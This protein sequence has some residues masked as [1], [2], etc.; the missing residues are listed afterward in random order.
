MARCRMLRGGTTYG[1][2]AE[3]GEMSVH[4]TRRMSK[5]G[6][7]Q[8]FPS[9]GYRLTEGVRLFSARALQDAWENTLLLYSFCS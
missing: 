6:R 9:D 5:R 4:N 8:P 7:G 3:P 2:V 1:I